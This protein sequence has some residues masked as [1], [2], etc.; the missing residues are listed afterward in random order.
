MIYFLLIMNVFLPQ[1][2][3]RLNH[4]YVVGKRHGLI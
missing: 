3:A 2:S 1:F 4:L